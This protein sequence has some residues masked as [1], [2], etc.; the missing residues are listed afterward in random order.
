MEE[1]LTVDDWD[2]KLESCLFDEAVKLRRPETPLLK[3]ELSGQWA[4]SRTPEIRL[5]KR[6]RLFISHA[7][8]P[9]IANLSL[10]R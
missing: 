2:A 8:K 10:V 4:G 5:S 3:A 9:K 6:G 1:L 7:L